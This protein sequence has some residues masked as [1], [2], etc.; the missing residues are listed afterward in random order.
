MRRI[1]IINQ[2]GGVGKTTT[3]ANLAAALAR[4]GLK[5]LLLDL[6][7]QGHLSLHFGVE[8]GPDQPTIYDVLTDS[9]PIDKVVTRARK[10]IEVVPSDIDLAGAEAELISVTGREVILREALQ[11]AKT[12]YDVLLI[13]CPPSLGVL[14]INALAAVDQV[15]IPL[16]AHFFG[17]QGLS[18]L[19]ETVTLVRQRI[20]PG[21]SVSGIILC[22]HEPNTKLATEVF[23]DLQKFLAGARGG[24]TPWANA[25]LFSTPVRRN[26]KLAEASSFGQTIFDYAPKSNGAADYARLAAEIF[27]EFAL[28]TVSEGL[29]AEDVGFASEVNHTPI[30]MV[31][32]A[33]PKPTATKSAGGDAP[34]H[35]ATVRERPVETRTASDVPIRTATVR[36]RPVET[37]T[38][39]DVPIRTATVRERPVETRTA[40]EGLRATP[41]TEVR[42]SDPPTRM[43]PADRPP[44]VAKKS[45]AVPSKKTSAEPVPPPPALYAQRQGSGSG[46]ALVPNAAAPV[47][48]AARSDPTISIPHAGAANRAPVAQS[49][50]TSARRRIK[51]APALRV[52]KRPAEPA[53][54]APAAG[55]PPTCVPA[56]PTPKLRSR[57]SRA[58]VAVKATTEVLESKVVNAVD[59]PTPGGIATANLEATRPVRRVKAGVPAAA[60]VSPLCSDGMTMVASTPEPTNEIVATVASVADQ[61]ERKRILQSARAAS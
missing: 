3:T 38:A 29:E 4:G 33:S 58:A 27:T 12:K 50:P 19:L 1:A 17:L 7:P 44:A 41:S 45:R 10:G 37:R 43:S 51:E 60:S 5:V 55:D 56:T 49:E 57:P 42:K 47:Q 24:N 59:R 25:R 35:T 20:N 28:P 21:L 18:K 54:I 23:E 61:A 34:I 48:V 32:A 30:K 52:T 2:K 8:V 15:V 39:G 14:T 46:T 16:Q 36:E 26:I 13:D 9:T 11:A 40:S 53:T 22:L 6:D 31:V